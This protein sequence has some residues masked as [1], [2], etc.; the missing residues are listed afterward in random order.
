MMPHEKDLTIIADFEDER[1]MSQGMSVLESGKG[2]E[3]DSPFETLGRNAVLF[4]DPFLEFWL[5]RPIWD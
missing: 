4:I 5:L 3:T 1:G 2:K